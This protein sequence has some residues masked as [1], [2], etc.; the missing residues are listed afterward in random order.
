MKV[1]PGSTVAVFGL[2]G[3]GLAVIMGC[4]EAGATRIIGVDINPDKFAKVRCRVPEGAAAATGVAVRSSADALMLACRARLAS[5][6]R[7][8]S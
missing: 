7:R 6:G 2:G 1:Q 4:K 8:S 5:L 3:V